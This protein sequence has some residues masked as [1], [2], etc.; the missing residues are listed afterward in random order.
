[1]FESARDKIIGDEYVRESEKQ[2]PTALPFVR[3]AL[4]LPTVRTSFRLTGE[5]H[6]EH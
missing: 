3:V 5:G 2:L 1:M 6:R 4:V